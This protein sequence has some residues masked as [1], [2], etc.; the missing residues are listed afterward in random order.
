MAEIIAGLSILSGWS[1][2]Y[3]L[4]QLTWKQVKFYY[5]TGWEIKQTEA[6]VYWG[7]YGS[8]MNGDKSKK[9]NDKPVKEITIGKTCE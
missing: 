4:N 3:I 6:K 8:L 2:E 7:T 9:R 1:K 5:N